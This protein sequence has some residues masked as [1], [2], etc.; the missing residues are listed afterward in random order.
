MGKQALTSHENGSKHR[1]NMTSMSK[2][3]PGSN[4]LKTK[5]ETSVTTRQKVAYSD[6]IEKQVIENTSLSS[7]SAEKDILCR[8]GQS[9]MDNFVSKESALK[10]EILWAIKSVASHHSYNSSKDI[11]HILQ[12]T[13]PDS[14]IAKSITLSPSKISYIIS[15]GLSEYFSLALKSDIGDSK[16]VVCF[17][18]A[19]NKIAQK[20]Q[21]DIILRYWSKTSN[22]VSTRYF[23]SMFL[24]HAT[25]DNLI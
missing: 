22:L 1:K 4:F 2:S 10:A 20:G 8:S 17:D 9:Q 24:G 16:L 6:K 5:D 23:N 11:S 15:F 14:K 3:L 13:F 19:M 18:E 7:T 21:M 12:L 25:A